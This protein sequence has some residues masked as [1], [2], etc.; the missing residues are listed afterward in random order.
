METV[1][2]RG[3]NKYFGEKKNR[4]HVLSDINFK[5]LKGELC[6]VLGPSG[7]GKSTFLT[8]AGGNTNTVFWRS[9]YWQH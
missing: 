2:L 7:S 3:I 9:T 4:I 5:A 8:I 6:L 1:I